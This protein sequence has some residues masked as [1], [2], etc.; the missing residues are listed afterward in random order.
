MTI[1]VDPDGLRQ[2]ALYAWHRNAGAKIAPFAGW[3]MPI[4]YGAG[5]IAEHRQVRAA[6]GLFDVSHMGQLFV[7]GPEAMPFLESVVSSSLAAL[8]DSESTYALLCRANGTVVDDI[9]VY[10]LGQRWLVVVNAANREKDRSWLI[11]HLP[12]RGVE[13]VDKSDDTSM[14]AL[15]GPRAVEIADM[16]FGGEVASIPRFAS[17]ELELEGAEVLVGRTGYTGEDGIELFV[18]SVSAERIWSKILITADAANISCGPIG[19]AARDSLRFE[20]GFPL[21]GHELDDETTPVEARLTWACDLEK[22][23]VGRDAI[24]LRRA[25]GAD[26]RL[27]TVQLTERGV[28]RQG[29]KILHNG[30][31]VGSVV[32]GMYA[33]TLDGYFA[34]VFVPPG[35]A[36]VGTIMEIEIRDRR[37]GVVVVKRPL[38]TPR[39]RVG[40]KP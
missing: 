1:T 18:D 37:K 2:T 12:A 34:N 30:D 27:A 19:L 10:R 24:L 38:Y 4:S 15:Q 26:K 29:N 35:L 33:P 25:N 28:P 39:Y 9:F 21:Y 17:R 31:D 20:P 6:A 8:S 3:E 11:E 13:I 5:A 23:F 16:L 22:E 32:S 7:G 40:D 36:K 14:F